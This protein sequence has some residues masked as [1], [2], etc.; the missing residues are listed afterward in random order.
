[1]PPAYRQPLVV[2][3][4][5]AKGLAPENTLAG[6]EAAAAAGCRGV[7]IDVM[8]S[9]DGHA[10]L[11]H[12]LSLQRIAAAQ[13]RIDQLLQAELAV[14]DVG[15]HF[16]PRFQDERMPTLGQALHRILALGLE[17]N[18]EIKPAPG[19]EGETAAETVYVVRDL[20][21]ADRPVPLLSSFQRR[22]LEVARDLA[23][24]LPRA[25]IAD[26]LPE[27]WPAVLAD[28]GCVGLHLNRR[29]LS[30][31]T[32]EAVHAAGYGLGVFTVNDA[33]EARRLHGWGADCLI[34]DYP[35]RL[36]RTLADAA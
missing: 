3:H 33:R 21:P 2:G 36:R 26:R 29:W 22:S 31:D 19:F 12:D 11:H 7:E 15:S 24:E 28:L 32:V 6:V 20:W 10:V 25:L 8:L 4:R 35:D 5:G 14:Y 34:T 9:A 17:A 23:P 13:G 27:D 30:A 1:M 18:L 16:H